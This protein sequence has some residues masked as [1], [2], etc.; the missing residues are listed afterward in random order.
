MHNT[1]DPSEYEVND[2]TKMNG[3]GVRDWLGRAFYDG[4]WKGSEYHG[5]GHLI[6]TN[7]DEYTGEFRNGRRHGYGKEIQS[8][9]GDIY[10]GTWEDSK[11]HGK[12]KLVEKVSELTDV[13][14]SSPSPGC[15]A[16]KVAVLEF[17]AFP[18]ILANFASV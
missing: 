11:M 18:E 17:L 7:G 4:E 8:S 1:D 12:G 13:S 10:E 5:H 3:K 6:E 2:E 15:R 14:L 9:T 16:Q